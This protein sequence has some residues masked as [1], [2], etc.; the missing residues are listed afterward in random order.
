MTT[1]ELIEALEADLARLTRQN[2]EMKRLLA[3][4]TT[5]NPRLVAQVESKSKL[6]REALAQLASLRAELE[7]LRQRES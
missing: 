6:G 1:E 5:T 3:K 4:A 2:E 7:A